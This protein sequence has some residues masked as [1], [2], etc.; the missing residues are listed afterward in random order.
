MQI[1][2][3]P[4][5]GT[6]SPRLQARA[7]N[8]NAP[9]AL[10]VAVVMVPLL[11]GLYSVWLGADSNWDLANYHMYNAYAFLHGGRLSI[12][13]APAGIQTYFNPLI[14]VPEYWM[15][16][17]WPSR[18]VG[19][20]MGALHGVI[21]VFALGIARCVIREVPDSDRYR[22]P[23]LVAL[24]CAFT[25]AVLT[26]VGNS[27]GDDTSAIFTIAGLYVL[28]RQWDALGGRGLRAM[29]GAVASGLIIGLGAGLKP[30]TAVC[31]VAACVA[32]LAYPA[33]V[34]VRL[35]VAFLF[36]V[37][38]SLGFAATAGY[39]MVQ[40]WL[41]FGN[42]VFPQ[43]SAIFPNPLVQPMHSGDP[44]FIPHGFLTV[45]LWPFLFTLHG[46]LVAEGPV[47]QL[48]WPLTYVLFAVW[49]VKAIVEKVS[50]RPRAAE[51]GPIDGRAQFV[52]LYVALGYVLW[53]K[54]FGIYRYIV[55]VEVLA[56]L[57]AFVL[58]TRLST[59]AVA[60]RRAAW[61]LGVA[62][63]L[64]LVGGVKSW[65]HEEWADPV[66]HADVPAVAHPERSTAVIYTPNGAW[67]WLVPFF[68]EQVSFAQ[69]ENRQYLATP[70]FTQRLH[71]MAA[72]RGGEVYAIVDGANQWR[73]ANIAKI[74]ANVRAVGLTRSALGCR[75]IAWG[76]SHFL[77][78]ARLETVSDGV[79]RCRVGLM[80][81]DARGPE[82]ERLD[83]ARR[84]AS[85][86]AR[87]GFDL[88]IGSCQP[89]AARIGK[90]AMEY[91]WCRLSTR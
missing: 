13:L 7:W 36:G 76:L 11:F 62:A 30:T 22:V 38:V 39:W 54:G 6:Q 37:G 40:L 75:A 68:P 26:G 86:F 21:F 24:A 71:E 59:Y 34:G 85:A 66:Y 67:A 32:L 55:G 43:F 72:A 14:D 25:P 42:P 44:R 2:E 69:I 91:Q 65:G 53:M 80:P 19:F 8:L 78:H 51:P 1:T 81:D 79:D 20:V 27:M 28:M 57:A 18:V 82:V 48:I 84:A 46:T 58:I 60:R 29:L 4:A 89:Y 52:L 74:D 87:H 73:A 64:P 47:H 63:L 3:D 45:L 49:A 10:A 9:F 61:W 5:V 56:P 41:M 83:L 50:G 12:D 35:R 31:A 15:N 17:H 33:S 77:V 90:G 70:V 23:L 16:T 88:D